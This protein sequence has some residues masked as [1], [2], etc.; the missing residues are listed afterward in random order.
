[1]QQAWWTVT[2]PWRAVVVNVP[3]VRLVG[4]GL[5]GA[6]DPNANDRQSPQVTVRKLEPGRPRRSR[7]HG[8]GAFSSPPPN[9]ARDHSAAGCPHARA[10]CPG[11]ARTGDRRADLEPITVRF[12][13]TPDQHD[14][15]NTF[16]V[17]LEFGHEPAGC[18][19]AA[20]HPH[21]FDATGGSI[22]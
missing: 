10:S 6:L 17:Q 14:R 15:W 7:S 1:M 8:A 16:P 12:V 4:D 22:E 19:H 2:V 3:C 9:A 18:S 11:F 21:P 5:T 20:A 13:Q